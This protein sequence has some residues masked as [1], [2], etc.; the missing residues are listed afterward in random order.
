MNAVNAHDLLNDQ[1]KSIGVLLGAGISVFYNIM[2]FRSQ[3]GIYHTLKHAT[4][5][6]N[7]RDVYEDID[8]RLAHLSLCAN[9]F[10]KSKDIT[11][12][13]PV[14]KYIRSK[15]DRGLLQICLTQN[16]DGLERL[17]LCSPDKLVE[18]HGS[19]HRVRCMVCQAVFPT[20][21]EDTSLWKKGELRDCPTCRH[22]EEL[23]KNCRSTRFARSF[24]FPDV[25]KNGED[26]PSGE[27]IHEYIKKLTKN[28][29]N[30]FLVLATTLE[31][32]GPLKLLKSL[33]AQQTRM[34]K[35]RCFVL[36]IS[37]QAPRKQ[38]MKLFDGIL[39]GDVHE[40]LANITNP[41]QQPTWSVKNHDNGPSSKSMLLSNVPKWFANTLGHDSM[42]VQYGNIS[43]PV[44]RAP[45]LYKAV[46]ST[47]KRNVRD[48]VMKISCATIAPST[49]EIYGC[50]FVCTACKTPCGMS[51]IG[52]VK[53]NNPKVIHL[54]INNW[55]PHISSWG[56]LSNQEYAL[57][58][59]LIKQY[60][61]FDE[62][63]GKFIQSFK[64]QTNI[65]GV[66]QIIKYGLKQKGTLLSPE[67]IN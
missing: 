59:N 30:V 15:D 40:T 35:K 56:E 9:I 28:P 52:T 57:L 18:M 27:T 39:I 36:F 29:P 46:F 13:S 25:L 21:S 42:R 64:N 37:N 62:I 41:I 45:Y 48:S 2:D 24:L 47:T 53:A 66:G 58:R 34:K 10:E 44:R 1:S 7:A 17:G 67:K 63:L 31:T 3:N 6:F 23:L 19:V 61:G 14:L 4:R 55:H 43:R 38:H 60:D 54:K 5:I 26:T 8:V 49:Q 22:K 51:I 20:T 33:R 65:T 32:D 50:K 11:E 12:A 16:I